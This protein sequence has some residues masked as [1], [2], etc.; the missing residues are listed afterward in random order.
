MGQQP[1][2]Q[3]RYEGH[4]SSLYTTLDAASIEALEKAIYLRESGLF[5]SAHQ[6][7]DTVLIS[8]KDV[9]VVAIEHAVVFLKQ[10]MFGKAA[11]TLESAISQTKEEGIEYRIWKKK[12]GE[13]PLMKI[14][15]AYLQFY[16]K[17]TLTGILEEAEMMIQWLKD[18]PV[19]KYT[20]VQVHAIQKYLLGI[21]NAARTS[22]Y[23]DDPKY[24]S[25][26]KPSGNS[27]KVPWKG[28]TDLYH[29]LLSQK[30]HPEAYA[31]FRTGRAFIPYKQRPA[32]LEALVAA[33][34]KAVAD[35]PDDYKFL[36]VYGNAVFFLAETLIPLDENVRAEEQIQK[37]EE[38]FN[39]CPNDIEE[40]LQGLTAHYLNAKWLRY[41]LTPKEDIDTIWTE[42]LMLLELFKKAGNYLRWSQ[43]ATPISDAA[44]SFL[45]ERNTS[46]KM[47]ELRPL[48]I[49]RQKI[50][51]EVMCDLEG[52]LEDH[53]YWLMHEMRFLSTIQP[54]LEW[55]EGFFERFKTFE[56]PDPMHCAYNAKKMAYDRLGDTEKSAMCLEQQ[57][58]WLEKTQ[59][60]T[61]PCD[62]DHSLK[63]VPQNG[64]FHIHEDDQLNIEWS[65]AISV[66]RSIKGPNHASLHHLLKH[67]Q[68]D[69]VGGL[70]TNGDIWQILYPAGYERKNKPVPLPESDDLAL[71]LSTTTQSEL[72]DC[73]YGPP[74]NPVSTEIWEL[75]QS[76]LDEWFEK[77]SGSNSVLWR[78]LKVSIRKLRGRSLLDI[79]FESESSPQLHYL[80]AGLEK[81]RECVAIIPSLGR[82][83]R[84]NA[85]SSEDNLRGL[86]AMSQC[87]ALPFT[88]EPFNSDKNKRRIEEAYK[89][90]LD[91]ADNETGLSLNIAYSRWLYLLISGLACARRA[92]GFTGVA[93]W[94]LEPMTR[95]RA[96][97]LATDSARSG[98]AVQGVT[99]STLESL[100]M[101]ENMT[102]Q[103]FQDA[104]PQSAIQILRIRILEDD[105]N[106][107]CVELWEILQKNKT[108]SLINMMGLNTEI[109]NSIIDGLDEGSRNLLNREAKLL[110]SVSSAP[111]DERY[112]LRYKLK[113]M[114]AE[115]R[116]HG[117][118][119]AAVVDLK[120]G[121]PLK[122]SDL[123]SLIPQGVDKNSV[124]FIDWY[125]PNED[126]F[127]SFKCISFNILLVAAKAGEVPEI[128]DTGVCLEDVSTL[129]EE[130]IP[131]QLDEIRGNLYLQK[132]NPLVAPLGK[133]S[134]PDDVLV[135][136]PSR[137]LHQIPFHALTV[138]GELLIKRNP[139]VYTHSLTLLR[140]CYLQTQQQQQLRTP[141]PLPQDSQFFTSPC[142]PDVDG[143]HLI[144]LAEVLGAD[145][146][147]GSESTKQTYLEKS[148]TAKLLHFFGHAVLPEADN[149]LDHKL[150]WSED[151]DIYLTAKEVF[152]HTFNKASHVTLIACK[153]GRTRHALGD[154]VMG[155]VPALLHSGVSSTVST[156]WDT[157][158]EVGAAF[159]RY[160][161]ESWSTQAGAE[162][163]CIDLAR[164]FQKAVL[165]LAV[166]RDVVPDDPRLQGVGGRGGT[167][168]LNPPMYWASFI[169]TGW[170]MI[171]WESHAV[172]VFGDGTVEVR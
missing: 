132:L 75:R 76:M 92:L 32:A 90:V 149:P 2:K 108:R 117:E 133:I 172:T 118:A 17:G 80:E 128:F 107:A 70:I 29:S 140:Y 144:E 130:I 104:I 170:W 138:D 152:T 156:L 155:L 63:Q 106:E 68:R 167:V 141:P 151:N 3:G 28:V 163:S 109:P 139:I 131:D 65:H 26:P 6:I 72:Y 91:I 102:L 158:G 86:I 164:T 93:D 23:V 171:D 136:C 105:S 125:I 16:T 69:L 122:F 12:S 54:R 44:Y 87:R 89:I 95:I 120:E 39:R 48:R 45:S 112:H 51:T 1:P 114:R 18:V 7:F 79:F 42:G 119:L 35:S 20:D 40:S 25:I 150:V 74:T 13:L 159:S 137:I 33:C 81:L 146:A 168:R 11:K 9:P 142:G 64:P 135:L 46:E 82:I 143:W 85:A 113:E 66:S 41:R 62:S 77:H 47:Q 61:K 83:Y 56:L 96:V 52:V 127:F 43:C 110:E 160:F 97:D 15:L 4:N 27:G 166:D 50:Q 165:K 67:M 123:V 22:N 134:K 24:G 37:A 100:K 84:E 59:G 126:H 55:Y 153:S 36:R 31:F 157:D 101:R 94:H 30:R 38:L 10:G 98:L 60:Y 169:F 121:V 71:Y 5:A 99:E 147:V 78:Y 34:E 14:F 21:H 115:M 161:Y 162:R 53:T 124:V 145:V 154:E 49:E 116:A 57:L 129:V 8:L 58:L 19:E 148:K 73:L 111:F 88:G 103:V